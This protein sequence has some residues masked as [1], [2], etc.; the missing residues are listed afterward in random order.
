M[1]HV[2]LPN[3][4][5]S[6]ILDRVAPLYQVDTPWR[7]RLGKAQEDLRRQD[8][9]R[10]LAFVG[11]ASSGTS[12]VVDALLAEPHDAT[13]RGAMEALREARPG[14]YG[15]MVR[16]IAY[17]PQISLDGGVLHIPHPWLR[18][19]NVEL[20][21]VIN[22]SA[23][24]ET[25]DALYASD[26]LY[27]VTDV[28]ALTFSEG[29]PMTSE[30]A[31]RRALELVTSFAQKP[32][33]SVVVNLPQDSFPTLDLATIHRALQATLGAST[34]SQLALHARRDD[35]LIVPGMHVVSSALAM[36]AKACLDP[37]H[38]SW[39]DFN[40]LF[41]ASRFT[42]LFDSMKYVRTD[43][44]P[45][46]AYVAQTSIDIAQSAE[47]NEA[48]LLASAQGYASVLKE[49]AEFHMASLREQ[50]FPARISEERPLPAH[51][52]KGDASASVPGFLADSR[53]MVEATLAKRFAWYKLF[54][55]MDELR[56]SLLYS[57]GKSFGTEQ[58]TRL[59]YEAGRLRG[60]A[61][62]QIANTRDA[63]DDLTRREKREQIGLGEQETV[64]QD[65]SSFDSAT[66]RNALSSF[67]DTQ[68]AAILVPT[69]LSD[70]IMCRRRQLL[71][72]NGPVDQMTASAQRATMRTLVFLGLS[73]TL[74]GYGALAH[75]HTHVP[76]VPPPSVHVQLPTDF[77]A[78]SWMPWDFSGFT[79][80]L[81]RFGDAFVMMPSTAAGTALFA[82]LCGAWYLQGRWT[83]IKRKFWSDW[84]RIV[85]AVDRD[86][87]DDLDALLRF[88][89]GAPLHASQVLNEK[90]VVR[91]A[92]HLERADLLQRLRVDMNSVE[93]S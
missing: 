14:M 77:I 50:I 26:A 13:L 64:A 92:R 16:T 33:T 78:S 60:V 71:S 43:M 73:Y 46:V 30:P 37:E 7:A 82:T 91:T 54:F 61:A 31:V 63:L 3:N 85:G 66:L 79:Q 15:T 59:A 55:R 2:A 53:H 83:S 5:L 90:A 19:A 93:R 22:P 58:E 88:V 62:E 75:K 34:M 69:C 21:E 45:R 52:R 67:N 44:L 74:C 4:A 49:Q 81:T 57:V 89:F 68:L 25:L 56:I 87:K 8:V 47:A 42:A 6:T 28:S 86:A 84:D 10:R 24:P 72:S 65:I 38:T 36:R 39:R 23:L 40:Q 18:D 48:E 32:G 29:E 20:V 9:P 11:A 1:Q 80:A 12:E 41:A 51:L 17:G 70:P 35:T 76:S 27:F